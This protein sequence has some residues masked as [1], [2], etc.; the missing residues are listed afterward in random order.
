MAKAT[1]NCIF[2]MLDESK[3]SAGFVKFRNCNSVQGIKKHVE[4]TLGQWLYVT[5][6][7]HDNKAKIGCY[8]PY[9]IHTFEPLKIYN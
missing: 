1:Y 4:K 8:S 9:N 6:Y 7:N 2:K 5:I 3:G